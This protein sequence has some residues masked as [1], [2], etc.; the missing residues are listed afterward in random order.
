MVEPHF[1]LQQAMLR[2]NELPTTAATAAH[3]GTEEGWD[4]A[5]NL[6]LKLWKTQCVVRSR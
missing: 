1:L 2:H 6:L 3:L 5:L 4:S